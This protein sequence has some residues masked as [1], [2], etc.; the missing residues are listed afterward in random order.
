MEEYTLF[1]LILEMKHLIPVERFV[2]PLTP[3]FICNHFVATEVHR[4]S[5]PKNICYDIPLK[6]N[7]LIKNKNYKDIKNFDI[8]QVQ[9]DFF[10]F[11]CDKIFPFIVEQNL[12]VV[13]LTSQWHLPQIHRTEKTD[14]LLNS[15]HILLWISQNPIYIDNEKYMSFPYGISHVSLDSYV[16]FL[17]SFNKNNSKTVK[18]LNQKANAYN[19]LPDNHIRKVYDIFGKNSGPYLNYFQFLTN[20]SNAEFVISTAGD[21]DECYRHYECIGLNSIPISNISRDNHKYI[22]GNNM[23]YSHAEEMV[24]MVTSGIVNYEYSP[25]NRDILTIYYWKSRVNDKISMLK[26][27]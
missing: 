23:I 1:D 13:I 9:V 14:R 2:T 21:R 27:K 10:D 7:D 4:N 8:I 6:G 19:H 22:Y 5:G 25:P 16:S 17:N 15:K 20:I 18:I 3:Y 11:F 26:L 12:Q 24:D